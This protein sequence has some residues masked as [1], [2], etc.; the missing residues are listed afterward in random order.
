VEFM[1]DAARVLRPDGT[2]LVNVADGPPQQFSR[3]LL[4][5]IR[6][7]LPSAA[8]VADPAVLKGRRFGNVVLA[9]SRGDLPVEAMSRAAAR[10]MFPRRVLAGAQLVTFVGK[11]TPLTDADP[12]RSPAPPDAAWRV[13]G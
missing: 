11:S 10:A 6:S 12:M 9:A 13:G 3:R 5:A 4:A 8:A 7:A 2:L 1:A